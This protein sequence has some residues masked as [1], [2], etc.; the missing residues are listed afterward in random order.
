MNTIARWW[1][2]LAGH[3]WI[4]QDANDATWNRCVRCQ[5]SIFQRWVVVS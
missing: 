3:D 2:W 5:L 1:C 4:T